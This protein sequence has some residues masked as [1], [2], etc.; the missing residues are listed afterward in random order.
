M[1]GGKLITLFFLKESY[2][3]V[4][5]AYGFVH[6]KRTKFPEYSTYGQLLWDSM[7][8]IEDSDVW[9][10]GF[11]LGLFSHPASFCTTSEAAEA[12]LDPL[13]E[14]ANFFGHKVKTLDFN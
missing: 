4:G 7:R 12:F 13:I 2:V 1:G 14:K 3:G 8:S 10:V 11:W 9:L 5:P 6:T